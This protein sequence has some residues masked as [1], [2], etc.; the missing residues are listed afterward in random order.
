V[1]GC[2]TAEQRIDTADYDRTTW[3]NGVDWNRIGVFLEKTIEETD[4]PRVWVG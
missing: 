4:V 1:R 2:G 3:N